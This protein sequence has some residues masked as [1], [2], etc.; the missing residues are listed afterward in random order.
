[1]LRSEKLNGEKLNVM[2]I[3]IILY[4]FKL[5]HIQNPLAFVDDP[6]ASLR[7]VLTQCA[8]RTCISLDGRPCSH[9]V[10]AGS[11]RCALHNNMLRKMQ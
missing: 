8:N 1:M 10:W 6:E 7:Q 5:F 4:Y 2:E 9:K 11:L 3:P